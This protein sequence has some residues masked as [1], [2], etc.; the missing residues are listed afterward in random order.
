MM[1]ICSIKSKTTQKNSKKYL[2]KQEVEER[3]NPKS[4]Q[5]KSEKDSCT[6][7]T[8]GGAPVHSKATGCIGALP[9]V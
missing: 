9:P 8:G 3:I 6:G 5:L 2:E 7:Y 4:T 1:H